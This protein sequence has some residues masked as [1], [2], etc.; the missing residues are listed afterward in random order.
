MKIAHEPTI[1][2]S[3]SQIE[4]VDKMKKELKFIGSLRY[5][6]GLTLFSF[7][8]KTGEIKKAGIKTEVAVM[9]TKSGQL[10]EKVKRTVH[11]EQDCIYIQCL[12]EKNLIKKLIKEGLIFI[13]IA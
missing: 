2:M 12:N 4:I 13:K 1:D 6:P 9:K 11:I 10:T 7:N 5:K 3:K 8:T